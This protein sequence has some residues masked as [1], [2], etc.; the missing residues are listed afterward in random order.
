MDVAPVKK[1]ENTSLFPFVLFVFAV[2]ALL[3]LCL[4]PP[5]FLPF[6]SG[7][8]NTPSPNYEN[9]TVWTRINV[10]NAKPEIFP[11]V[12]NEG[13]PL[14]PN[15]TL[16]GG[17]IRNV[18]CNATIRDWN[19][20]D[21]NI[22]VNGSL[23]FAVA[24]YNASDDNNTHYTNASCINVTP[25]YG[26][27]GIYKN[28]TCGFDTL[29]YANAGVW[30]CT[31]AAYDI[32][33][34]KNYTVY[35]SNRTN[36]DRLF[37]LNVTDG[38][39]YG[40]VAVGEFSNTAIANITNF[41][42]SAINITVQGYGGVLNDGN[43]FVCNTSLSV[44]NISVGNE[45]FTINITNQNFTEKTALNGNLQNITNLTM[46]KQTDPSVQIINSTAWQ[47]YIPVSIN[48]NGVCTG[49]VIFAARQG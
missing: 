42:N 38:I 26:Q 49:N 33:D 37:S 8:N 13:L 34:G 5:S 1:R 47:V 32:K 45:A 22:T 40:D 24:G 29:Y 7:L 44:F 11:V 21:D 20:M 36:F 14:L 19:G 9:V 39:D 30:N 10:T 48:P 43:A 12:I 2:G 4:Q 3:F 27:N 16:R 15:I 35:G 6:V 46:P 28:Y 23:Y 25:A 41:G 17:G 31:L 18:L